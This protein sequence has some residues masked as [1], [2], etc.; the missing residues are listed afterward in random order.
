MRRF[1]LAL[2]S[3]FIVFTPIASS[4]DIEERVEEH[5]LENG[6][7][8]LLMERHFSPTVAA[9][10]VFRAGSVDEEEDS[11]GIAHMLEHMLFKGTKT[12]GTRDYE[13]EKIILKEIENLVSATDEERS[14][15]V[16]AD[17]EKL[18]ELER[19]LEEK[20]EEHKELIVRGEYEAIYTRNGAV[21]FNA[22]TSNDYTIY[23]INLPSNRLELWAFLESDRLKNYVLREF[24]TEREAVAEERRMRVDTD[25]QGKL[26]EKFMATAFQVHPYGEPIIGYEE[27]IASLTVEEAEE[28]FRINYAPNNSAIVIVGDIDPGRTLELL[29]AY[30]GDIPSQPQ[31]EHNYPEEP[32][33]NLELIRH[34]KVSVTPHIGASTKEAQKRIGQEIVSIIKEDI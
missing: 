21:G 16:E 31:P 8:V 4:Q 17:K 25:P 5:I 12:V 22:G 7:K 14:R 23:T 30:F 33:Q 10:I 3:M 32:P 27:D 20:Q 19:R 34:K 24:Y 6:F 15:G 28:Y 1:L 9:Y 11:R 2:F 13:S 18:K 26:Y 29:R